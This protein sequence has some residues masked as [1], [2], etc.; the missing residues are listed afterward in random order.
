MRIFIALLCIA[1]FG[2]SQGM[3]A[4]EQE[5]METARLGS[6]TYNISIRF[7][8]DEIREFTPPERKDAINEL[9]SRFDKGTLSPLET[10]ELVRLLSI[11]GRSEEEE[12]TIEL[13]ATRV[14]NILA[15]DPKN[16]QALVTSVK[17]ESRKG[18]NDIL[19][20]LLADTT[21]QDITYR[22]LFIEL[23]NL[24]FGFEPMQRQE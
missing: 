13:L 6:V 5:L 12:K 24:H 23:S 10:F 16:H 9:S 3:L 19:F 20:S 21:L 8:E 18:N 15:A 7:W 17:L 1:T 4:D 11:D 22:S 2:A 14:D